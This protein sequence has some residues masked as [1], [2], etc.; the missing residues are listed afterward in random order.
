VMQSSDS[1]RMK[2]EEGDEAKEEGEERKKYDAPM[3]NICEF[4]EDQDES[5]GDTH[6][7][8][9]SEEVETN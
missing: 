2:C 3:F 9:G 1:K 7:K 5:L 4:D 8:G 6:E